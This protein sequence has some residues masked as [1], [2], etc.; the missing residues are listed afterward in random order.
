[1]IAP[2]P[3]SQTR[4]RLTI[5]QPWVGRRAGMKRYIRTWQLEP[6]PAAMIAALPTLVVYIVA[7]KYFIR[8]LT[9]G[10]VKG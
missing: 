9:A 8:G 6:I 5:I 1:M 10:S 3:G 2:A 4:F 7:G